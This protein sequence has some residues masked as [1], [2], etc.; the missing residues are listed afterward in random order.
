MKYLVLT[1]GL[2]SGHIIR[3]NNSQKE[4][5]IWG[6]NEYAPLDS[7]TEWKYF[8]HGD[9]DLIGEY[10][11]ISEAKAIETIETNRPII[12]D[13]MQKAINLA[14][15]SKVELPQLSGNIF[16]DVISI[17]AKCLSNPKVTDFVLEGLFPVN[18]IGAAKYDYRKNN[19]L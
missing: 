2:K 3:I 13:F 11:E 7:E 5:Y 6:K 12:E 1:K 8:Y 19:K 4:I 17:V 15:I 14:E 16:E 10:S 18:I 9:G